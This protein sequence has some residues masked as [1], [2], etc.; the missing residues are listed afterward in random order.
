M[1]GRKIAETMSSHDTF[2]ICSRHIVRSQCG[3][4]ELKITDLEND[5]TLR[6][7]M[8]SVFHAANI[9]FQQ[10]RVVKTIENHSSNTN[11]KSIQLSA[12]LL[13]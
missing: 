13:K 10:I 3:E 6:G 12:Q 5:Q 7:L 4:L 8:L 11:V 1:A 2:K 9:T